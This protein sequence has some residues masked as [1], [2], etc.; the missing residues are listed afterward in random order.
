MKHFLKK[1]KTKKQLPLKIAMT[2]N[3]GFEMADS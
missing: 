3:S 2:E 1:K